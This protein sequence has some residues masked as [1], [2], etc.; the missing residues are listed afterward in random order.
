MVRWWKMTAEKDDA[1]RHSSVFVAGGEDF[2][3]T[4]AECA[5]RVE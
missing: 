3:V 4:W 2:T 5:S 1:Y